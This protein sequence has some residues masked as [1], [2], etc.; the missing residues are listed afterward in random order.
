MDA[1]RRLLTAI[2]GVN[3]ACNVA[4][5][6]TGFGPS[7]PFYAAS[8]L[9]F[10]APPFDRIK[11]S[12]YQPAIEAGIGE[13]LAE[14]EKIAN[15]PAP[16]DF[17]NTILAIEKRGQLLARVRRVFVAVTQANTNPKR[18]RCRRPRR[19]SWRPCRTHSF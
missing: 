17:A 16:P 1:T 7:N 8:K 4:A 19:P 10:Q 2:L 5:Q 14:I 13:E 9:P 6:T 18:K 3:L 12:D 11:D 15:N